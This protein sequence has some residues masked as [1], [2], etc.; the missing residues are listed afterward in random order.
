VVGLAQPLRNAFSADE[1]RMDRPFRPGDRLL[2][3]PFAEFFNLSNRNHPAVNCV[4]TAAAWPSVP[5]AEAQSGNV[6]GWCA[7]ADG[8]STTPPFET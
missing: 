2:S 8:S 3:R 6:T 5:A 4:T 7:N 1:P